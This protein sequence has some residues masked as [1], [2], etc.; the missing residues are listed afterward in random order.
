[1]TYNKINSFNRVKITNNSIIFCDIDETILKFSKINRDW[2]NKRLKY[3]FKLTNSE[4][5]SEENAY[6]D[7]LT[8]VQFNIPKHTDKSGLINMLSEINDKNS[9]IYFITARYSDIDELTYKHFSYLDLDDLIN[10]I[11]FVGNIS[12]GNFLKNNFDLEKYNK[13]IFIDD[14]EKNLKDV[15]NKLGDIVDIYQFII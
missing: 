11:Y 8:Y 9:K 5:L 10:N 1:M 15:K 12:K 7:W 2:W 4:E 6:N 14:N 3:Y 13:I